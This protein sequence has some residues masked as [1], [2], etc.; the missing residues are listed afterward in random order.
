MSDIPISGEVKK[1]GEDLVGKKAKSSISTL[2]EPS[3]DTK[4]AEQDN[5]F[6][7]SASILLDNEPHLTEKGKELSE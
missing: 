3:A 2:T 1:E 6:E 5:K 4:V 7:R